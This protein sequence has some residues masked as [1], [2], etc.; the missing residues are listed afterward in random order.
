MSR[1][2]W[3]LLVIVL[4]ALDQISKWLATIYAPEIVQHN[5]GSAFSLGI[6]LW[7][8]VIFSFLVLIAIVYLHGNLK[9]DESVWK[10]YLW[11]MI[12]AGTFGNLIDRLVFGYVVDF[13]DV[14][15]WSVFNIADVYLSIGAFLFIWFYVI[16]SKS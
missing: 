11:A 5:F 15:F 3:F 10:H 4:I 16:K 9:N 14:G 2:F 6:P 12:F 8:V 1:F 7:I 13:I